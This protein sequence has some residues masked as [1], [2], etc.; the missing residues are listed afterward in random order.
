VVSQEDN[1]RV[2]LFPVTGRYHQL[3]VHMLSLDHPIISDRLYAHK[4]ALTLA[5]RLNLHAKLLRFTHPG[6]ETLQTFH[7]TVPF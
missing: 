6:T 5:S 3:R 7:S 4:S 2:D 1:S